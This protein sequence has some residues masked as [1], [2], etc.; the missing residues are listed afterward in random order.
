MGVVPDILTQADDDEV[1]V[2][3]GQTFGP[4]GI[5]RIDIGSCDAGEVRIDLP[6]PDG[7]CVIRRGRDKLPE[8]GHHP[9]HII[10]F[11]TARGHSPGSPPIFVLRVKR[12]G[13]AQ[14]QHPGNRYN[15]IQIQLSL[16]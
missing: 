7:G 5:R 3:I 10:I 9:V 2:G 14:E 11:R 8:L 12:D 6:A 16:F 13:I 1:G 4:Q 15:Y